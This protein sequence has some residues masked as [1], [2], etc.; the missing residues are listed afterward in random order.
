M[1]LG[2]FLSN[3]ALLIYK[4]ALA[5]LSVVRNKLHRAD[6]T[7][8]SLARFDFDLDKIGGMTVSVAVTAG[9]EKNL[10]HLAL[11]NLLVKYLGAYLAANGAQLGN[12]LLFHAL[13]DLILHFR[14][15]RALA[16]GVGED[17]DHQKSRL[18]R[19]LTARIEILLALAGKAN[20]YV[21]GKLEVGHI[22]MQYTL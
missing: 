11:G 12:T 21:G 7:L 6:K 1:L 9:F 18:A 3:S 13:G 15:N 4:N 20:Y 14:R 5:K 8:K 17:V 22:S 19:E 16:L 2:V 10:C